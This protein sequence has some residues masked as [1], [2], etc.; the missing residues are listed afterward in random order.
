[1]F[2]R[3]QVVGHG[4]L[5]SP[6]SA[7]LA[8]QG[9]LVD[10]P[11]AELVILCVPDRA[12][13]E[14]AARIPA[15]PWIAHMSGAVPLSALSPHVQRFSLHPLQTFRRGGGPEQLDGASAAVTGES[16]DARQ[17]ARWLAGCL[18]LRPFD[19]DEDKRVLYHAGAT[20]ASNFLVTLFRASQ[21]LVEAAGVPADGLVP[22]MRQTIDNGFELTG[23]ISRGDWATVEAHLAAIHE[24]APE[25]E[26]LY[27]AMARA[28]RP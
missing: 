27:R 26:E 22:L 4:R 20:M 19:L 8:E 1:M 5:G 17:R 12:I 23:P 21:Q 6:V 2:T 11:D 10:T 9:V 13:G 25:L 7:R 28:T 15:G 18:R 24:H 14:V 3:V 16:D